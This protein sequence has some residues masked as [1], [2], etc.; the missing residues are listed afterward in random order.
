[1]IIKVAGAEK[2]DAL[3][4][5]MPERVRA[6]VQMELERALLEL[7]AEAQA[8]TP[9]ETGDLQGSADS[10]ATI[11]PDGVEGFVSFDT[12]YATRQHEEMN[13]HHTAPGQAKY[14]ETP[15]KANL[16]SYID[17][18]AVKAAKEAEKPA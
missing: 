15:F 12:P 14:L 11:T 5:T 18:I 3:L 13:Y 16:N 1:M 8:I 7:R 17:R 2:L 6:E 4:K 10:G 9:V